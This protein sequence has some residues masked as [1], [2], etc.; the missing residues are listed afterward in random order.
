MLG[1]SPS[2]TPSGRFVRS[3]QPSRLGLD[4]GSPFSPQ[5]IRAACRAATDA[6]IKSEHDGGEGIHNDGQRVHWHPDVNL[7]RLFRVMPPSFTQPSPTIRAMTTTIA[8]T[9]TAT[10]VVVRGKHDRHSF[11]I[12][13]GT[14]HRSRIIRRSL[15]RHFNAEASEAHALGPFRARLDRWHFV[16]PAVRRAG[17]RAAHEL[18]RASRTNLAFRSIR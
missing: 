5:S 10:Q 4:P 12:I 8:T 17:P 2:V 14:V 7:M 11:Q 9:I 6:R 13:I 1:S 3:L 16:A 18:R 15:R